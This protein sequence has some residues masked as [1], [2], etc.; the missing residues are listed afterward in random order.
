MKSE[1]GKKL[2]R[3]SEM[4]AFHVRRKNYE[5]NNLYVGTARTAR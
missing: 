5:K 3:R 2:V 4:A 1:N